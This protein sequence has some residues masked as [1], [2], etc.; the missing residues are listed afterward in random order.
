MIIIL[1]Y[2]WH[3]LFHILTVTVFGSISLKWL[4]NNSLRFCPAFLEKLSACV[5]SCF[6]RSGCANCLGFDHQSKKGGS[7]SICCMCPRFHSSVICSAVYLLLQLSNILFSTSS[8]ITATRTRPN[9]P[10]SPRFGIRCQISPGVESLQS[11]VHR[12][13]GRR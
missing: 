10:S 11:P 12:G 2:D 6:S 7:K 1:F 8:K 13:C 3:A 9:P 5:V 4:D